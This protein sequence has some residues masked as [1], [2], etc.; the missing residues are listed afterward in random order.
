MCRNHSSSP[1]PQGSG[2]F[3]VKFIVELCSVSW[4]VVG[5]ATHLGL[6][7]I[8]TFFSAGITLRLGFGYPVHFTSLKKNA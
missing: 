6:G 1:K 5:V 3:I 4:G 8:Q 7:T 2:V